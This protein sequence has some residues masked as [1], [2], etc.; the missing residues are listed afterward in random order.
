VEEVN[1]FYVINE[2]NAIKMLHEHIESI[3]IKIF[4]VVIIILNAGSVN[5]NLIIPALT[6]SRIIY[7]NF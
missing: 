5:V 1:V 6:L 4:Y 2:Q 7:M 3:F